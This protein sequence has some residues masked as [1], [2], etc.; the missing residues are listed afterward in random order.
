ME[1]KRRVAVLATPLALLLLLLFLI[2]LSTMA[3]YSI[4][5]GTF[6]EEER[7]ILTLKNY[8]VFFSNPSF[9]NLFWRTVVMALSVGGFAVLFAYPIAYFLAFRS[10]S[11]RVTL[12]TLMIV[13]AWTSYLLRIV[14]IK[15]LLGSNGLI[16][17]LL[18]SAG[19]IEEGLPIFLYSS[20][21]VVITLVYVWIPFASLPIFLVLDRIDHCLLEASA[22]LG[23]P[24]WE[25]FIRVTLPLSIPGIIASLLYVFI[26]TLGDYVTPML[27]GGVQSSTYFGNLIQMQF[28]AAMDWPMGSAF[29]VFLV[30]TILLLLVIFSRLINIQNFFKS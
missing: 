1:N 10:G 12:L 26:P 9:L 7:F 22:D 28:G 6:F 20:K 17:S 27:M 5:G 19:L 8:Q 16:N 15:F 3:I 18:L 25:T 14:A 30:V 23:C 13:P 11:N 21:A 24:P 29:S 2:P 4:R